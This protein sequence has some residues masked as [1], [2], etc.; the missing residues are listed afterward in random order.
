MCKILEEWL[1]L[2]HTMGV[3]FNIDLS[4]YMVSVFVSMIHDVIIYKNNEKILGGC[5]T[6]HIFVN[7]KANITFNELKTFIE[8]KYYIKL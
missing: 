7:D 1:D 6:I 8:D 3:I 5:I 4:L 2:V